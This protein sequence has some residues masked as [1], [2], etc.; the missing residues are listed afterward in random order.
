VTPV[1]SDDDKGF[2]DL[3]VKVSVL[4]RINMIVTVNNLTVQ[5]STLFK[6][7]AFSIGAFILFVG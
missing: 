1:S 3:V 5:L 4:L 2:M 6:I 7:G